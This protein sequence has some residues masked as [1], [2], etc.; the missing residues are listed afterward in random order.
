VVTY[1]PT[2]P[3]VLNNPFPHYRSLR[4]ADAP[5]VYLQSVGHYA[6][7]RYDEAVEVLRKPGVFGSEGG[8]GA[9]F[10][11]TYG[12]HP[13][14]NAPGHPLYR[15]D[16][17][18]RMIVFAD[19]PDHT[20]IRRLISRQFSARGATELQGFVSRQAESVL[21]DLVE[22]ARSGEAVD[23]ARDFAVVP[24][25]V[26]LRLLDLPEA[27]TVEFRHWIDII[28]YGLGQRRYEGEMKAASDELCGFFDEVAQGRRKAP[29]DD[30]ISAM[31]QRADTVDPALTPEEITA[32]AIELFAAGTDTT[33]GLLGN[34]FALAVTA[35]P[36]LWTSVRNDPSLI[37]GSIEE[38]LRYENSN[39]V[40]MR[41]PVTDT[42]L[43]DV[44]LPAGAPVMV[45]L[46]S[47]NRDER[48]F[49]PD[50]DDYRI[51]RNPSDALGFGTGIHLCL[52]APLARLEA[53]VV[54]ETLVRGTREIQS[55]GPVER[56]RSAWV[57]A[58]SSV[59]VLLR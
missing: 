43:G 41:C 53:R 12:K 14:N 39:Q 46:G 30:L 52:G 56:F 20:A 24:F 44:A 18:G 15:P 36:D 55:A 13:D 22:R 5:A 35:R 1:D 58:A 31:V 6:I 37:G 3:D 9:A 4:D 10:D 51:D 16:A 7:G 57:R 48:H 29:G 47:A 26:V 50:A 19:P 38:L 28:T 32:F 2:D 17:F 11:W 23:L 45:V 40:V 33:A 34:W 21:A 8:Y 25:R 27:D 54:L 59:P 42:R 49:G